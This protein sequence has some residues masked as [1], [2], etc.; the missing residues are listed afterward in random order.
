MDKIGYYLTP[1]IYLGVVLI[2]Q[3]TNIEWVMYAA[4]LH[5][6]F[7]TAIF[8]LASTFVLAVPSENTEY[9]PDLDNLGIRFFN[10]LTAL[11]AA[12]QLYLI[13]FSFLAGIF[14]FTSVCM[15]LM[16]GQIKLSTL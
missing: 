8:A 14:T 12:Y 7:A 15:I 2:Y 5:G 13:G 9:K 3:Y 4:I 11:V 16:I 1:V 6:S 10:Q